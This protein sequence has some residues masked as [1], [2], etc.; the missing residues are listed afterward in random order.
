MRCSMDQSISGDWLAKENA[1]LFERLTSLIE[2]SPARAAGPDDSRIQVRL[3]ALMDLNTLL[4]QRPVSIGQTTVIMELGSLLGTE[5]VDPLYTAIFQFPGRNAE[6]EK[7]AWQM[8]I[9]REMEDHK[10]MLDFIGQFHLAE[11]N[12]KRYEEERFYHSR[13]VEKREK[14]SESVFY[15]KTF[16]VLAKGQ[17]VAHLIAKEIDAAVETYRA[18]VKRVSRELAAQKPDVS[19]AAGSWES[20]RNEI[21]EVVRSGGLRTELTNLMEG[22]SK[23]FGELVAEDLRLRAESTSVASSAPDPEE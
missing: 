20:L 12:Q 14:S 18:E 21:L 5:N 10:M 8:Y 11:V 16:L 3:Q 17:F 7:R 19:N 9:D 4:E 15:V 23:G 1:K 13:L 22:V 6:K 2:K